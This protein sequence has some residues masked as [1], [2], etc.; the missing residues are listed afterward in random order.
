VHPIRALI[1][2]VLLLLFGAGTPP[3]DAQ[4]PPATP[5]AASPVAGIPTV[6]PLFL[7]TTVLPHF[8][9][10]SVIASP[11]ADLIVTAAHCVAG[12]EA[13]IRFA[14]GYDRGAAPFGVWTVREAYVD[15]AWLANQDPRHDYAILRLDHQ[16]WHGRWSGVQDVVGANVLGLAPQP[17]TAVTVDGYAF[18]IND[19]P[20]RCSEA[21][22][23]TDGYPTLDCNGLPA[24][25]SG[26]PWA[27]A[28]PV[29]AAHVDRRRDRWTPPR[30]LHRRH[31]LQ[32]AFHLA[33]V[34][35][36]AAR[37]SRR[38]RRLGPV[39]R[40]RRLLTQLITGGTKAQGGGTAWVGRGCTCSPD[41]VRRRRL[42]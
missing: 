2:A 28:H 36:L 17:G 11:Q 42:P 15:P 22:E 4:Q 26:G 7:F 27:A 25:T 20:L 5:V 13:G 14:P 34:L 10:A 8:C 38:A 30:R 24:G 37:A 21:V 3:A 39:S 29:P 41:R 33:G 12:T 31:L 19:R 35:P 32:R 1:S 6:G 18:G 23:Q 40:K 9:S 16:Q